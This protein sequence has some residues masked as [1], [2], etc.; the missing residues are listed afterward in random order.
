ML[1]N[2]KVFLYVHHW[3]NRRLPCHDWVCFL[4]P[5][6]LRVRFAL[7]ANDKRLFRP[8]V[9]ITCLLGGA[10]SKAGSLKQYSRAVW[11]IEKCVIETFVLTLLVV[12]FSFRRINANV[13]ARAPKMLSSA[14]LGNGNNTESIGFVRSFSI[15]SLFRFSHRVFSSITSCCSCRRRKRMERPCL[16]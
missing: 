7:A 6:E 4:T 9:L 5:R 2:I 3:Q 10:A 16:R 12:L 15:P 13:I 1:E 11:G 14:Q 8:G